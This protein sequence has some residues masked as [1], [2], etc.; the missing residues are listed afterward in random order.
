MSLS[1]VERHLGPTLASLS[2]RL[3][4][5]DPDLVYGERAA[6][7]VYYR[8]ADCKLQVCWSERDGGVDFMLA[9]S[10]APNEF[11]IENRSKKWHFML[12]LSDANDDLETPV[13][14]GPEKVWAWR[15]ALLE[16]HFDS[17]RSALRAAE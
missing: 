16:A 9:P 17:A 7:A 10:D 6:W 15:K 2:F 5:V 13:G 12:A 3:D 14:A 1:D 4:E 8:G 11:G